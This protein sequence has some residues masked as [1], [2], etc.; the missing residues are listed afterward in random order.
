MDSDFSDLSSDLVVQLIDGQQRN[1]AST[2]QLL[3]LVNRLINNPEL[4]K[5][6]SKPQV[7][8]VKGTF[9]VDDFRK[10]LKGNDFKETVR[11]KFGSW[12]PFILEMR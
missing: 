1:E 10:F 4:L 12:A 6:V 8:V 2:A 11:A 7:K 5:N 3:E 9:D